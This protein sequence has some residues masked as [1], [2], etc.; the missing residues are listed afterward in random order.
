MIYLELNKVYFME[1]LP[2]YDALDGIYEVVQKKNYNELVLDSIDIVA[3][4]Y[5]KVG[6]TEEDWA[7]DAPTLQ[8]DYFYK[9]E[10]PGDGLEKLFIWVPSAKLKGYPNPNVKR[11]KRITLMADLGVIDDDTDITDAIGVINNTLLDHIGVEA[12]CD[13]GIYDQTWMTGAEY[14][15]VVADRETRKT[16]VVNP[17]TQV[18]QLNDQLMIANNRIAALEDIVRAIP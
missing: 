12:N 14:A 8:M 6:L 2:A 16:T 4:F 10:F 9:L 1:F 13:P 15:A 18:R 7:V 5:D 3:N 11:Y 17:V